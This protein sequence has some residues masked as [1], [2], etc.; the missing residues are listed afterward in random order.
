[1]TRL[2]C[3]AGSLQATIL[4]HVLPNT[5]TSRIISKIFPARRGHLRFAAVYVKRDAARKRRS[6]SSSPNSTASTD[7]AKHEETFHKYKEVGQNESLIL[8]SVTVI[9]PRANLTL[10]QAIQQSR[11]TTFKDAMSNELG[12][13]S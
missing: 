11:R 13:P 8:I 3:P 10:Y 6:I 12:D 4:Q 1:M 5:L 7:I 2:L 9:T